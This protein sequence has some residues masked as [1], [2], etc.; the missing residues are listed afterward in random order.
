MHFKILRKNWRK[1]VS[2]ATLP[3]KNI[4]GITQNQISL[5]V[6][7]FQKCQDEQTLTLN[8]VLESRWNHLELNLMSILWLRVSH[9]LNSA[10]LTPDFSNIQHSTFREF[11]IIAYEI[12]T[13]FPDPCPI[14][15]YLCH[16]LT[17]RLIDYLRKK[18][19][20]FWHWPNYIVKCTQ[21]SG[22]LRHKS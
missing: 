14:F 15:V 7:S 1:K 18:N 16:S 3:N 22:L 20:S 4:I 8:F 19:L 17:H 6:L 2:Q 5:H 12:F 11:I 21:R 13:F 10:N 9:W